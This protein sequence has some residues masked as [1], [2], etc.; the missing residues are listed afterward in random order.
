MIR[1]TDHSA[2]KKKRRIFKPCAGKDIGGE[3]VSG[4]ARLERKGGENSFWSSS[5]LSPGEGVGRQA[6]KGA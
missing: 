2:V 5:P 4:P 1:E 3:R 6:K